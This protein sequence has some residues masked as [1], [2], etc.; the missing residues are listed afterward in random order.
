MLYILMVMVRFRLP[1]KKKT[2]SKT[3]LNMLLLALFVFLSLKSINKG[4]F[5]ENNDDLVILRAAASG[6]SFLM[7][8]L[9][10]NLSFVSF[11]S[12]ERLTVNLRVLVH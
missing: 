9:L 8:L 1:K 10:T 2:P 3:F 5:L 12:V 4:F 6:F 7:L 11:R